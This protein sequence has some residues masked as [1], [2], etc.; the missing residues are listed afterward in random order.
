MAK[1]SGTVARRL[2]RFAILTPATSPDA[3]R[4]SEIV[5]DYMQTLVCPLSRSSLC[6][7]LVRSRRKPAV[8]GA[9]APCPLATQVRRC[10]Q[11]PGR[12]LLGGCPASRSGRDWRKAVSLAA[13]LQPWVGCITPSSVMIRDDILPVVWHHPTPSRVFVVGAVRNRS[14]DDVS[15]MVS[16]RQRRLPFKRLGFSIA[17]GCK[18]GYGLLPAPGCVPH[19]D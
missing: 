19:V 5:S 18:N 12:P 10:L 15:R 13:S 3:D 14:S 7:I 8:E 17:R 6:R 11:E 1:D 16:V 9:T 4:A 2:G